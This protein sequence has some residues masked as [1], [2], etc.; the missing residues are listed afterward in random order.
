MF[1]RKVKNSDVM[2][3]VQRFS[4]LS[5]ESSSRAKHFRL[6]L[7]SLSAQDKGQFLNEYHFEAFHLIDSILLNLDLAVDAQGVVEAESALWAL[8]QVL[9]FSPELVGKGWQRYAIESILKRALHPNNLLVV[10]KIAIRLFLTWYQTLAVYQRTD[11]TLDLVFQTILPYFPLKSKEPTMKILQSYCE[12]RSRESQTNGHPQNGFDPRPPRVTPIVPNP[13]PTDQLNARERAQ[14]LQIY[15]DKFLEYV[16]REATRIEWQD[17]QCRIQSVKFLINRVIHLYI[18]EVFDDIDGKGVDVFE[19]WEGSEETGSPMDTA[20]PIVIARYWLIRWITNIASAS[21]VEEPPSGA[22]IFRQVMFSDEKATN[23][24]L[25]LMRESMMLPLACSSVI[26]KVLFLIRSWLL[27]TE[28][29]PFLDPTINQLNRKVSFEYV[30]ILLIN[31]GTCFFRSPYLAASGDRLPAAVSITQTILETFRDLANPETANLS[32]PLPPKVWAELLKRLTAS[33]ESCTSMQHAYGSATAGLLTRSLL[34]TCVFVRVIREVDCDERMWD[35]V[36]RVFRSSVWTQVVEQWSKFLEIMTEALVLNLFGVEIGSPT[37]SDGQNSTSS[38]SSIRRR[39]LSRPDFAT[40]VDRESGSS[41][42]MENTTT[43][44]ERSNGQ[45][46]DREM[47]HSIVQTTP[48]AWRWLRPWMRIVSAVSAADSR[49]AQPAVQT[50][51][52]AID[53]VLSVGCAN[54]LAQW[55]ADRLLDGVKRIAE[56]PHAISAVCAVLAHA[57]PSDRQRAKILVELLDCLKTED[58]API[59]LEHLPLM[60]VEDTAVVSGDTIRTLQTLVRQS[61]FSSRA[62]RVAAL[63]SLTHQD[64]EKILLTIL[65][66]NAVEVDLS[67]LVLCVNALSILILE[68]ADVPLLSSVLDLLVQHRYYSTSLLATFCANLTCAPRLGF[69]GRLADALELAIA[70]AHIKKDERILNELK[71]QLVSLQSK[72]RVCKTFKPLLATLAAQTDGF[73]EG[74]LIE[75]GLQFPLPGFSISQWGSLGQTN[76]EPTTPRAAEP[77]MYTGNALLSFEKT[78]P[79]SLLW[80]RTMVGRHCFT[81]GRLAGVPASETSAQRWLATV[82]EEAE[83]R[84]PPPSPVHSPGVDDPFIDELLNP[85]RYSPSGH[86]NGGRRVSSLS[87]SSHEIAEMTA[88]VRQSRR[89]P[90]GLQSTTNLDGEETQKSAQLV[91]D[92]P[93]PWRQFAADLRLFCKARAAESE[94]NFSRDLRH[95][96]QTASR[97]FHKVAVIYVARGQEEK[98]AILGNTVGSEAFDEFVSGL[99]WPVTI[100]PNSHVGYSG[101]LPVDQVAPYFAN[102]SCELIFHVS[103]RLNGEPTQ[104]LKHLGNDEVHVVWSEHTRPYRR[105]VIATRFCDVLIV[106]QPVS[107]ALVRVRVETQQA[108]VQFGPLFDGAQVHIKE[109][110]ALVRETVINASRAYR[111][112]QQTVARPNKHRETVFNDTCARLSHLP[113]APAITATFVPSL[114]S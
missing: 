22:L 69:H 62:V 9:C 13:T 43:T 73:L 68:R 60:N 12:G 23:T 40:D 45:I 26:H 85:T 107:P 35:D 112:Q 1:A 41:E 97:E 61:N 70:R 65:G 7:D 114:K 66:N 16:N 37:G 98:L 28:I 91:Q 32:R 47:M 53:V 29:P 99:G 79:H 30:N 27:Q 52:R 101:G 113:I 38:G 3:S 93:W 42:T 5:R 10:R 55:L 77:M 48:N 36:W 6:I 84:S 14:T 102:E 95:L 24:L 71:W 19:G 89:R 56:Q 4:D 90:I 72:D 75:R 67:S 34:I 63:L 54:Q 18:N 87:T 105:D 81:V 82:I 103:T 78:G 46:T 51:N 94:A 104:K 58:V 108:D 111:V 39:A 50:L 110:A 17:E 109:V 64:A 57:E 49:H 8:E 92:S 96:D 11:H 31:I 25:T 21:L 59:V 20:D 44:V 106:L 86:S 80:S 33:V 74:L 15:L 100:G 88:F 83:R 2:S 76:R